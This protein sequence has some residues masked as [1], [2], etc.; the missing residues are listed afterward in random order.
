MEAKLRDIRH[1]ITEEGMVPFQEWFNSLKDVNAQNRTNIRLNR[2]RL[3]LFGDTNR[4]GEG[5]H[6]LKVDYGPGYRVYFAN[7]GNTIVILLCGGD[8]KTQKQDIQKA[9]VY[10]ADYK[11]R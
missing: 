6:E 2:L 7:E 3:G 4:I 11:K 1:Y 9:K 10:W 8:K 5:V